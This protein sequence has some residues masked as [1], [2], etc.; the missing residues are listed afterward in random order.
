M[1][2]SKGQKSPISGDIG[3]SCDI[4]SY[5]IAAYVERTEIPGLDKDLWLGKIRARD[6]TWILEA[7]D[8]LSSTV[9]QTATHHFV[10]NQLAALVRKYPFTRS[11]IPEIDPDAK[12]LEKFLRTE[13]RCKRVNTHFRVQRVMRARYSLE[14]ASMRTYIARIFGNI[15]LRLIYD[16]CDFGPGASIGIHGIGTNLAR[17]LTSP[18]WSVS[19]SAAKYFKGAMWRNFHIAE[20]ILRKSD[21]S[22][23]CL[24]KELF[25]SR[26]E[27]RLEYCGYNKLLFVPKTA[28]CSRT[29]AVEP[30]GNSFVQKGVDTYLRERIKHVSGIDLTDQTRNQALAFSG[31]LGG[32]DPYVTIDLS[33]ASDSVSIE[34]VRDILSPEWFAFLNDLRSPSYVLNGIE[35]PYQK[36]CSMGN[37]FCFPLETAIFL[38]ACHAVCELSGSN[39][40]F[41]VYGDD[42]II[43]QSKA[44]V[45]LELLKALGFEINPEKTFIYGPFR[46]SCG[47]DYFEGKAV[48]P[49]ILDE[50]FDS[51]ESLIKVHNQFYRSPWT[52]DIAEFLKLYNLVPYRKRLMRDVQGTVDSA[53]E[54]PRDIFMSSAWARWNQATQSWSWK[55]LLHLGKSDP[56]GRGLASPLLMMAAVRGSSS[57]SPFTYRR[58]TVTRSRFV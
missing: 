48:R 38:A 54:V 11:E 9:Y 51:I 13:H 35:H 15:D 58:L 2:D 36:F 7:A 45:L 32:Y 19:P 3:R 37:G 53:F 46:E 49:I 29:I 42:I 16:K 21:D 18:V 24:D 1:L 33:S 41:S 55:E 20:Y 27:K 10:A 8:S 23:F 44:L 26:V 57:D 47:E 43:R 40:D 39:D 50:R 6:F 28:K 30:L 4:Y 34:L 31:S 17:K 25:D 12:A 22:I 56:I 14:K 52:A 5:V